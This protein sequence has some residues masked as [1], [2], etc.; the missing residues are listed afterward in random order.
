MRICFIADANH[1]NTLNWASYLA[2]ELGNE[3]HLISLNKPQYTN[4]KIIFHHLSLQTAHKLRYLLSHTQLKKVIRKISPDIVVGYR[5]T[6]YAYLAAK[7][8]FHP[9]LVVAQSQKAAGDYRIIRRPVQWLAAKYAVRHCDLALAWGPHMAADII[10]LGG[11]KRKIFTLPRGVDLRIFHY[12]QETETSVLKIITTRGLNKGYNSEIVFHCVSRLK[13]N[14]PDIKYTV[15]GDGCMKGELKELSKSLNIS[16]NV[17]F[18]GRIPYQD[19]PG[20]LHHANL[21]ISPVPE[22]GVS[23]SLLEA[24]AAGVFP[25]VSDIEANKYWIEQGCSFLLFDSKSI[26]DLADKIN[27][28]IKNRKE[29]EKALPVNR[30]VVEMKASWVKNMKLIENEIYKAVA[31]YN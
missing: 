18:K 5:L 11:D 24:M 9:L 16:D 8:S 30:K 4:S 29:F 25:I 3:I 27:I 19:I 21:Y 26:D 17:D 28:Y 15:V 23:S 13:K 10:S 7:T 6:S 14:M 31:G 22:D 1:P 2:S 20:L 12:K